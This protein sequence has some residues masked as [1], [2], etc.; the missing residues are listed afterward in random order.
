MDKTYIV[1]PKSPYTHIKAKVHGYS[2]CF[3]D[4]DEG[5]VEMWVNGIDITKKSNAVPVE[6]SY[7]TI[8]TYAW[9][10]GWDGHYQT[11]AGV[12]MFDAELS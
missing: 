9:C 4:P 2:F 12:C 7:I 8:R 3:D 11:L 1:K 10:D 6:G 5:G